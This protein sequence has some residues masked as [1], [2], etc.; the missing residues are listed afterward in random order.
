MTN[1]TQF[2]VNHLLKFDPNNTLVIV[3]LTWPPRIGFTIK[4]IGV[5]I[6]P[7][8][9]ESETFDVKHSTY[10]RLASPYVYNKTNH[11]P[12]LS[13]T[14]NHFINNPESF[15]RLIE[16]GR[17]FYKAQIETDP[18][19]LKHHQ[20]RFFTEVIMLESF[21]I[22]RGFDYLLV[23]FDKDSEVINNKY[24]ADYSRILDLSKV[25]L[26]NKTSHPNKEGAEWIK[27]SIINKLKELYE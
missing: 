18:D 12:D 3:G 22:A 1:I 26:D 23:N 5:N 11:H 9:L 2:T 15:Q 14:H 8:D 7:A 19:V 13:H 24:I 6:T 16:K 20:N 27:D 21:L 10:R 25:D 17:D 4:N